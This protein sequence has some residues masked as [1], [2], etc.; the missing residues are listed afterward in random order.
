[1]DGLF[2]ELAIGLGSSISWLADNGVLFA[3]FSVIWIALGIALVRSR[4]TMDRTWA[5]L[6]SLPLVVQLGLWVLFLP[7]MIGLWIWQSTWP[8]AVRAM[9][10]L[11][12]AAWNL[13][14]FLPRALQA[15]IP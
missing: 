13:V 3:A 9:L 10:V 8:L 6:R 11:S 12:I 2:E 1:M 15:P 7:V 14:M 5:W 4:E